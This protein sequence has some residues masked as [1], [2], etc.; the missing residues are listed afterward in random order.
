MRLHLVSDEDQ[1]SDR[2]KLGLGYLASYLQKNL[3]ETKLSLSFAQDD[4]LNDI[5]K[6]K[7][8]LVGFSAMTHAFNSQAE[9]AKKVKEKFNLPI[10]FGGVHIS[11]VPQALPQW[12]D[13]GVISEGEE[14]LSRLLKHFKKTGKLQTSKIPALIYW[15]KESL[16]I[17]GP[18]YLI[19]PIDN[20]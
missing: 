3:P 2:P 1:S 8:D 13:V 17:T 9:K 11:L 6:A 10:I 19:E 16:K 7:P 18:A 15:Q 4:Y 12:V 20:R 14:T 5:E